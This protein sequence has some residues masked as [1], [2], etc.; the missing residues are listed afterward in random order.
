MTADRSTLGKIMSQTF[1]SLFLAA[2]VTATATAAAAAE[3]PKISR[4]GEYRGYTRATYD[5]HQL[6][7]RY[8]KVRDGT[9][10]AVDVFLPTQ[11]G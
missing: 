4:P 1:R 10:L 9:R 2:I 11:D 5:G 3:E 6:T 7:S 8:I